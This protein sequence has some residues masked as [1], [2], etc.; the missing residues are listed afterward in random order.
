MGSSYSG[1]LVTVIAT[2]A[3]LALGGCGSS[4]LSNTQLSRDASRIC[5]A[6]NRHTDRIP[7]PT[8]T[9]D[10]ATFLARG[11]AALGPE[12]KGLRALRPPSDLAP[13]YATALSGSAAELSALRATAR[14]LKRGDDPVSA[15]RT[16]QRRLTP[17]ESRADDAWHTLKISACVSR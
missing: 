1:L 11:A 17:M 7:T 10:S 8:S 16:L 2:L 14:Q 9:A 13:V 6:A 3:A 4:S 15:I 12:L 5:A